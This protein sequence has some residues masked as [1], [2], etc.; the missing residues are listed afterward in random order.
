MTIEQIAQSIGTV[1][2]FYSIGTQLEAI[3]RALHTEA[4]ALGI[5]TAEGRQR[6]V[7]QQMVRLDKLCGWDVENRDQDLEELMYGLAGKLA[8]LAWQRGV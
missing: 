1:P 2:N 6:Y 8:E 5:P 7:H 4:L 3:A